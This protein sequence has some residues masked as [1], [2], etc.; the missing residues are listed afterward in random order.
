MRAVF[1]QECVELGMFDPKHVPADQMTADVLTK[2][3]SYNDFSKHRAKLTNR[4]AQAKILK[5]AGFDTGTLKVRRVEELLGLP[6]GF[7]VQP[8]A[9]YGKSVPGRALHR[10]R[11][12][13]VAQGPTRCDMAHR[14]WATRSSMRVRKC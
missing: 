8:E 12:E 13:W 2:W 10:P 11:T 7:H 6:V 14:A 5:K 4:R 1:C 9:R 3:L